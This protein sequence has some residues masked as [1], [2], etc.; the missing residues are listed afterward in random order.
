MVVFLTACALPLSGGTKEECGRLQSLA[1]A[2]KR[3]DSDPQFSFVLTRE[4]AETARLVG[5][6]EALEQLHKKCIDSG[7][8]PGP[9][10][11]SSE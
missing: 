6:Q 9:T 5:T 8:L 2:L 3:A 7:V 1:L 11:G 4:Q 10:H